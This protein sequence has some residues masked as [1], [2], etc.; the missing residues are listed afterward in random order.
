[1]DLMSAVRAARQWVPFSFRTIGYG[2]VSLTLGPLT[3]DRRASLWAMR[4]WCRASAK[5]LDILVEAEDTG[6]IPPPPFVYCSNHQSLLD[7][8]VLG[9]SLE[10]DFKWAAKRSLL[11]IPFLGWHLRL[12]GHVPVDRKGG[13]RQAAEVI[14]RFEKVLREGK[15]LLIFPEGTRSEDGLIRPF[16]NGGF[17][18]AVR[19]EVPVVP[20]A[21]DGTHRLMKKWAP[22]TGVGR[23]RVKV[24]APIFPKKEGREAARVADLRERTYEAIVALHASIGGQPPAPRKEEPAE[25]KGGA[26]AQATG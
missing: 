4:N 24:G 23:V 15:P 17:Y 26:A 18:A 16:K 6:A 9:G 10:G 21:L 12:A 11:N 7:I 8:L 1:M 20:V 25:K 13:A 2:T 3:A 22:S 14:G 19:A 5:A